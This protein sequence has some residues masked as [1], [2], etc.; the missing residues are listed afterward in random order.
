[1]DLFIRPV[2]D[3]KRDVNFLQSY[4]D[5]NAL[6]LSK[7]TGKD[8]AQCREH[9]RSQVRPGGPQGMVI[10]LTN[11][12]VRGKNG[13]RALQRMPLTDYLQQTVERHE[14][15]APNL[16]TYLPSSTRESIPAQ[17]I[18][19]NLAK[20]AEAKHSMLKAKMAGDP[21]T[22][23]IHNAMQTTYK[24]KNNALS[25]AHRS[26]HTPL[27]NKSSHSTL[28]SFCRTVT[29]YGNANNEKFLMGNR[30]YWCPDIVRANILSTLGN[31][32]LVA[33]E[34]V[35]NHH[36]LR[37]PTADETMQCIRRST[38]LYFRDA[39]QIADIRVL[40]GTLTPIERAAFVYTGDLYHLN[41]FNPGFVAGLF[42]D[43]T[44]RVIT[45]EPEAAVWMK[46]LDEDLRTC[47]SLLCSDVLD[48]RTIVNL[49][50]GVKNKKTGKLERE[51]DP[52]A[53][54]LLAAC[55]RNLI[56]SIQKYGD[57]I[58]TFWVSD[59]MPASI[60]YYP[61]SLRR[62][63]ITSDTDSTIFTV[64]YWVKL[65]TTNPLFANRGRAVAYIAVY[66]TSQTIR[67]ILAKLSSN[68][69]VEKKN[70]FELQMK[71][72]Y[73]YP[74]FVLTSRAKHYY[75]YRS[76][77]EGNVLKELEMEVKG[78][79]LRNSK[80]PIYYNKEVVKYMK[81]IL[82][83]AMAGEKIS[84]LKLLESFAKEERSIVEDVRSGKYGH[85]TK[86]QV[87]PA[88]AY[89][90]PQSSNF[91]HYGMWQKVFAP[92]YGQ[93]ENPP[94]LGVK[95]SL[96]LKS[97]SK[98]NA[99]LEKVEDPGVKFRMEEWLKEMDKTD[100]TMLLMPESIL[101]QSGV[102]PEVT[103]GVD[104]RQLIVTTMEAFYIVM[105][106]LG[107]YFKSANNTKLV[108]DVKY[109]EDIAA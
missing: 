65:M 83:A 7:M 76:A 77:Q 55:G 37:T 103:C 91:I 89:K 19:G 11:A 30:H 105:E 71:N 8:I 12:L 21:V 33:M 99:W 44:S 24:Y 101:S 38:D 16:T 60:S 94:Y 92:K 100:L 17:Y 26:L 27:Y 73:F 14:I 80:V 107:L 48:G 32:D 64:Q 93:A 68:L 88:E 10:P 106:S 20:R 75:A 87:K 67:H 9:V 97:K 56:E 2:D 47:V 42:D 23:A 29:S 62:T 69:G 102:P 34:Q 49:I 18:K 51:P 40:V 109:I 45:P 84:V 5:Q 59:A 13:D 3:Y 58:K 31:V 53:Y 4:I 39:V 66:L 22:E 6:Y 95:V 43:L 90:N 70:L 78:V 82:N 50:E 108:S 98:L 46:R 61:S 41:Q 28:T 25:G 36:G 63:A 57:F 96:N 1:M 72:E 54:G 15:I 35:L 86:E 74:A 104:L 52:V 85:L 81:L 79:A